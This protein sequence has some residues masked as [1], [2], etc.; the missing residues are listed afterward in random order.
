MSN[1]ED[2]VQAALDKNYNMANELFNDAMGEKISDA[3][4][5]E[6]INIA[7]RIYNDY[8]PEDEEIDDDEDLDLTDE[9]LDEEGDEDLDEEDENN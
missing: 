8:S 1:I 6:K 2:L 3:I 5:Q 7:N 4:E 9:D